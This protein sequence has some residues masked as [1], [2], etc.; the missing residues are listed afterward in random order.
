MKS[1]IIV[2]AYNEADAIMSVINGIKLLGME[3]REIIV[4]DD[5]S[6]DSTYDIVKGIDGITVLKHERNMGKGVALK[7]GIEHSKGDVIITIDADGTYS[8]NDIP[9]LI[10]KM[11]EGYDM[12]IGSRFLGKINSMPKIRFFG[13]I[14]FSKMVS[15]AGGKKISDASSG[16]RAF[17]KHIISDMKIGSRN[18]SWEVEVTAKF[19]RKG[20]RI[21]EVPIEYSERKGK[22]KLR[23]WKD[24]FSFLFAILRS[25]V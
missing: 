9:G 7:T 6:L 12:A 21:A 8:A 1:S 23:I 16:L 4:V 5:G 3:D 15:L 25:V 2:P 13:N 17:R 22:S 20:F 24:G 19:L 14:F 11:E 18:L 10:G